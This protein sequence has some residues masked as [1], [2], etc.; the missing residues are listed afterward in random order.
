MTVDMTWPH[1]NRHLSYRS[2]TGRIVHREIYTLVPQLLWLRNNHV[3]VRA[4]V[5]LFIVQQH[6]QGHDVMFSWTSYSKAFRKWPFQALTFDASAMNS[7]SLKQASYHHHIVRAYLLSP[8]VIGAYW[9]VTDFSR[10]HA[11]LY[12]SSHFCRA[13]KPVR[14]WKLSQ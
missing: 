12:F 2:H 4:G 11:T 9:E 8:R 1:R 6:Q 10:V 14:K 5:C 13:S 3:A 7:S